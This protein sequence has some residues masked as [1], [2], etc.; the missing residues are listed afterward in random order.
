MRDIEGEDRLDLSILDAEPMLNLGNMDSGI[1]FDHDKG[2]SM[3]SITTN[4]YINNNMAVSIN[5]NVSMVVNG[6][7]AATELISNSKKLNNS[8]IPNPQ[9]L[10]SQRR[11]RVP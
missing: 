1:I 3:G 11:V 4:V 2:A 10:Q 8:N 7:S 9:R 6:F 5:K